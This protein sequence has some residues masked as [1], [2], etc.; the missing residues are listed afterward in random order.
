MVRKKRG[1]TV[2]VS[3][4]TTRFFLKIISVVRAEALRKIRS[5]VTTKKSSYILPLDIGSI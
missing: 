5:R 2:R 3:A 4:L 1:F